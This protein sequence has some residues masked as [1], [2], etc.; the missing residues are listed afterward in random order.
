MNPNTPIHEYTHL[1]ADAMMKHNKKEWQ[2]V[3]E[4]LRDT[5]AWDEVLKDKNYQ[6]IIDNEGTYMKA[7]NGKPTN[8][9]EKQWVQV[10]T[11]A[12]KN[13]FGDWEKAARIE[14]FRKSKP[15]K[16]TGKE[17]EPSDDLKQYKKNALEYGKNLRGEYTN[18]DTGEVIALTGGNSRGGIR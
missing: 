12:F 9:N 4:L 17:I 16:I 13:W 7:P 2:S 11:K 3:K 15:V 8:L 1:W 5:P 6:D 18:E 10:R 14:K